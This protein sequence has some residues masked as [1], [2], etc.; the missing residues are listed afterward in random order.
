MYQKERIDTILSILK[1]N[2]YVSV[3]YLTEQLHYSTATINRDLNLMQ[4]EGLVTRSYGGV[5]LIKGKGVKLSFRYHLMK[6]I[7]NKIGKAAADLIKD[8][9]T[10]FIDGTTTTE[11]IGKYLLS[12]KRYNSYNQ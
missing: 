3:K 6:P 9:D 1:L 12:K 4:K 10:I 11:Y 2:G 5:E 7:K 8:G